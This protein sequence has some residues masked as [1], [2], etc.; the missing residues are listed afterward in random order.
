MPAPVEQYSLGQQVEITNIG[1]ELKK[2]WLR[3]EGAMTRASLVNLALYS[4]AHDA[5]DKNTQI[6]AKIA[7]NHAC[8]AIVI[9]ADLI[10]VKVAPKPGS[11]R[12]VTSLGRAKSKFAPSNFPFGCK[13][14]APVCWPALFFRISIPICRF[15]LGGRASCRNRWIRNCGLGSIGSFMTVPTG[16]ISACKCAGSKLRKRR[17]NSASSSAI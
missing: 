9:S 1:S 13:G 17:Q 6:I 14:H 5:L 11:T 15:I 12:I 16:K 3:G 10:R 7:D 2:L 4:E 8:R